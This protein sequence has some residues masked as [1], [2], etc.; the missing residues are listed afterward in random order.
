MD[1]ESNH[2]VVKAQGNKKRRVGWWD[3]EHFPSEK[4]F[5]RTFYEWMKEQN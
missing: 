1:K 4:D 3:S 2:F 5:D